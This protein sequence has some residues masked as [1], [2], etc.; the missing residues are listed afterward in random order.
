[1]RRA[2]SFLTTALLCLAL[3]G[4]YL[5]T[6]GVQSTSGGATTTTTAS[7]V[8][9]SASF[10]GGRVAFSSGQV[11]PPGAPGGHAHYLGNGGSALVVTGVVLA[12]FFNY[13]RGEPRPRELPADTKIMG[14]CSCYQKPVNSE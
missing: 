8:S 3:P 9:G 7:K 5:S 6:Y 10:P 13:I 2:A 4:C 11:P 1:M 14:T 12:D